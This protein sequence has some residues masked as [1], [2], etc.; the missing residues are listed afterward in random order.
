MSLKNETQEE[1]KKV[2]NNIITDPNGKT[3]LTVAMILVI[4]GIFIVCSIVN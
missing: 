4:G 1:A 2:V 3:L